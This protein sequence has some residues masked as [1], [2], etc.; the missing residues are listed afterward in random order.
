[1]YI[2]IILLSITNMILFK[3]Y[4]KMLEFIVKLN[5]NVVISLWYYGRKPQ[6]NFKTLIAYIIIKTH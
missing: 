6:V 5:L 4:V 3:K 2:D 1:M